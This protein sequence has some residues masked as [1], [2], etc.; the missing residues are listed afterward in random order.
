[1]DSEGYPWTTIFGGSQLARYR[2]DGSLDRLIDLPASHPALIRID[3][4]GMSG[5]ARGGEAEDAFE[6]RARMK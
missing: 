5:L 3:G 4:L 2:P 1:M 6:M